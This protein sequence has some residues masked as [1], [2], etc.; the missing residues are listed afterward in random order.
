LQRFFFFFFPL[1]K[2]ALKE[3]GQ[4]ALLIV[5]SF[6]RSLFFRFPLQGPVLTPCARLGFWIRFV[7]SPL[8]FF[9]W[10]DRQCRGPTHLAAPFTLVLSP[11]FPAGFFPGASPFPTSSPSSTRYR[12]ASRSCCLSWPCGAFLA[13]FFLISPPL[14]RPLEKGGSFVPFVSLSPC[15]FLPRA[16]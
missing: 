11:P 7:R 3:V 2:A 14:S 16:V 5:P 13:I 9:F 4:S 10:F 15:V 1:K 6:L 12:S 8:F